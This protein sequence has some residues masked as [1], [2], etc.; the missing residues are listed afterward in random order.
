[1]ASPRKKRMR[2]YYEQLAR[3]AEANER[4]AAKWVVDEGFLENLEEDKPAPKA[5]RKSSKVKKSKSKE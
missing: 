3:E 5:K 4:E 1:M 2:R